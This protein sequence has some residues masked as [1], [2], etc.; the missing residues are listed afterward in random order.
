MTS[1]DSPTKHTFDAVVDTDGVARASRHTMLAQVT[2]MVSRLAV[3]VILARLLTPSDFG[4]VAAGIVIMMVA[5]QITDLGTSS[6]IIQRDVIDDALVCSLFYVNLVLG[7]CLAAGMFVL[8]HPLAI[9][10]RQPEAASAIQA[11]S[12]ICLI[13]ALGNMHHS[14]LRRTLQFSRL[15][16]INI[17][18]AVTSGVVG[19]ALAIA[20]GGLWA[21]V[22]GVIA[23][24]SVS[25]MGAWYYQAWRP[26]AQLDLGRLRLVARA[27]AHFFYTSA[28]AITF[29]QLDKVIVSRMLGGG[30]LGTYSLAQRTVTAP[31]NT[32]SEAVSTVSFSVFARDQNDAGA[33]RAG[34]TRAGGV[35]A[36][37]VLPTTVGLAVLAHQA[38]VVV[39]GARWDAAIPVVEILAPL[40]AVQAI[41][42]VPRSLM[43]AMG[44]SD[45]LYRWGLTYCVVGAMVMV[46]ASRW[47]L[48]GVSFGLAAVVGVLAPIE[49]KMALG[50]IDMHLR[51]FVR[52]LL[53]LVGI[54]AIMGLA[55]WLIAAGLDGVGFGPGLQLVVGTLG[56]VLVF[57]ALMALIRPMALADARRVAGRWAS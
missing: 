43:Y 7:V 41:S 8:A 30:A 29:N 54:S 31:I 40:A 28:L 6:V 9:M 52:S 51:T 15:A 3:N 44:R 27:S 50:L 36:L 42:N 21:L 24:T 38:V 45:W 5:W 16:V 35:V 47:G 49:M 53:P 22:V 23:G 19:I 12:S 18:N 4:V 56:G 25:T 14:L 26:S 11:L 46:V 17:A 57:A 37:V 20:G 55:A 13:G 2:T 10:L 33:L 39:Y 34:A 1:T 48:V 32:V